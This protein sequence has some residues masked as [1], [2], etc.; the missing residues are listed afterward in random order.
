MAPLSLFAAFACGAVTL[1]SGAEFDSQFKRAAP[2]Q[3]EAEW[4]A[5][6]A[7]APTLPFKP[8]TPSYVQKALSEGANWTAKGAVTPVKNQGPHGYC[9]TFGRVGSAEGQFALKAGKLVSFSEEELCDCIG[10]DKDQFSWFSPKGFMTTA[11]YPYNLTSYPPTDPPV[12]GNPCRY[13]P[14]LVVPG[15]ADGFFNATTG[16]A[17]TEEQMAAFIHHNGPVSAGINAAVFGLR[18]KGCEK[19]GSC[20][21][22][23]AMCNEESIKGKSIDHRWETRPAP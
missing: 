7:K 16:N 5:Q 1:P 3:L 14:E 12:P 2:G 17:P 11:D 22:T 6:A 19:D 10:W 21:I 13:D 8:F 18:E 4:K 23:E 15:S 9:G 20:F